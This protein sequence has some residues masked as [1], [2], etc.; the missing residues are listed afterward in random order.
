MP[1]R[2]CIEPGCG[3]LF[4]A[5]L[6]GTRRCPACQALAGQRA[7]ARR[8]RAAAGR[9]SAAARGYGTAYR[10]QRDAIVARAQAAAR[11]GRPEPCCRG[12]ACVRGGWLTDPADITA[13]HW[14]VPLRDGGTQLAAAHAACNTGW[15]RRG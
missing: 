7:A 13:D 11:A 6:T 4:D 5:D 15:N 9:P 12:D 1:R 2:W 14:P 3:A 10:R 8:A